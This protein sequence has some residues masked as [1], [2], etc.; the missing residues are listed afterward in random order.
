[1][2]SY[3]LATGP[4]SRFLA[5]LLTNDHR[6]IAFGSIEMQFSFLGTARAGAAATAGPPVHASFLAVPGTVLPSPLPE[7]PQIVEG[8][9]EGVYA[10]QAAFDRPGFWQVEVSARV[11]GK[12]VHSTGA[13]QVAE[14]HLVPFPGDP[15]LATD[16][17]TVGSDAPRAAVDSRAGVGGDIPDPEL[18]STTIAAAVAA[19]RPAVVVFATPV[20]CVSRFC[21]PVTDMVD[22][23]AKAYADRASFVHVEIWF[24]HDN[25]KLNQA[26][27]DWLLRNGD[28]NEPWVFVIGAD[29]R[30][31]ARFDNVVTRDELEPL[32]KALPA[33]GPVA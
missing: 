25:N 32:V 14:H 8:G 9:A 24:D 15:A 10:A 13:F 6:L 23:L 33:I 7:A 12:P 18:H 26:A 27:Q 29:G 11:N 31:A 4:P 22:D 28:L 3:D 30:I 2:A 1:M 5:G 19:K 20:F 17:L 16:N 21:G